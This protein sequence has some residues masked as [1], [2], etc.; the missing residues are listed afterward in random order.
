MTRKI[1]RGASEE[2]RGTK[3]R[4]VDLQQFCARIARYAHRTRKEAGD[5]TLVAVEALFPPELDVPRLP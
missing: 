5:E 4:H 1:G 3:W 2:A